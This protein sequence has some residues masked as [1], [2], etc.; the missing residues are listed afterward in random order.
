MYYDGSEDG[1]LNY[2]N[3]TLLSH[4]VLLDCLFSLL[5][6]KEETFDGFV[7]RKHLINTYRM[8]IVII[9]NLSIT[10]AVAT[11]TCVTTATA[12]IFSF[13]GNRLLYSNVEVKGVLVC[14]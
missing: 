5:T 8:L 13:T 4:V 1:I 2:S 11:T 7:T 10:G 3:T 6:S 12:D 9:I 14:K